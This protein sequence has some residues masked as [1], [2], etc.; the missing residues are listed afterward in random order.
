V[1]HTFAHVYLTLLP[2]HF[3]FLRITITATGFCLLL[4]GDVN[5]RYYLTPYILLLT[6]TDN[7]LSLLASLIYQP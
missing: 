4:I 3:I 2:R 6:T 7:H 5:R 1:L